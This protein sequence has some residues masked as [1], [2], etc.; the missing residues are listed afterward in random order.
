MLKLTAFTAALVLATAAAAQGAAPSC[1]LQATEKKL[2]GAAKNSFMKR[3][4][5]DANTACE[6][7]ATERKLSGAAK[8]SFVKKCVTDAVGG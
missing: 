7:R 8:N 5:T 4:E 6:A 1:S 2:S 3:C